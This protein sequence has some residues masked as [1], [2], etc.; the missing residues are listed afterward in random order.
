MTTNAPD[1]FV[2]VR[3]Q[4]LC[5]A[6]VESVR[7]DG[8]SVSLVSTTGAR[9]RLGATDAMAAD[10]E[11]LQVTLGEGPYLDAVGSLSP[12]QVHD[13][14][15]STSAGAAR[16]PFLANE[17]AKRGVRTLF[18]FPVTVG[19]VPVGSIGL[20]RRAPGALSTA[21]LGVALT[22]VHDIAESLMDEDAWTELAS[23]TEI[24]QDSPAQLVSGAAVVLQAA[25]MTMMQHDLGIAEATAFLHATAFAE[26]MAVSE[27]AREVVARR[28]LLSGGARAG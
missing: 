15:D 28:F 22:A 5:R 26:G 8:G 11:D 21:E 12:V 1:A 23:R 13:L 9:V 10:L 4:R 24:G 19:E 27:L 25:G 17:V 6:C 2:S 16:W 3:M 18:A 14:A 7:V 20:Y